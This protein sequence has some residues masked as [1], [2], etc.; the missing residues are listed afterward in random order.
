MKSKSVKF[1]EMMKGNKRNCL[2]ALRGTKTCYK[3]NH[4]PTCESREVA[5]YEKMFDKIKKQIRNLIM[6]GY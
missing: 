5:E 2:S 3:C 4:Y 6:R 1:S